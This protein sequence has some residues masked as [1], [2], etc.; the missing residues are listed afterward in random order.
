M[1]LPRNFRRS[2]GWGHAPGRDTRQTSCVQIPGKHLSRGLS[3]RQ[4]SG[5]DREHRPGCCS[6]PC[7][8]GRRPT[9]CQDGPPRRKLQDR[10]GRTPPRTRG[11]NRSARHFTRPPQEH[12]PARRCNTSRLKEHFLA[13]LAAEQWQHRERGRGRGR[14]RNGR[15][16]TQLPVFRLVA[17]RAACSNFRHQLDVFEWPK[18][19]FFVW[20]TPKRLAATDLLR[21]SASASRRVRALESL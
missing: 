8:R 2:D 14:G 5:P 1:N 16:V 7:C 10:A 6:R 15:Q 18:A 3:S 11:P 13:A 19:R 17:A 12:R 20:A 21:L 4:P 9:A